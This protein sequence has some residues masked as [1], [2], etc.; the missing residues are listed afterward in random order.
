METTVV[1]EF[2]VAFLSL[3][4]LL[5][6]R[7]FSL[8][9]SP[10]L[11]PGPKPLPILG[12]LLLL[13]K[14]PSLGDCATDLEHKFGPIV[15]LW[16]W[17]QPIVFISGPDIIQEAMITE[18]S[19]FTG[20]PRL[21][22]TRYLSD[23]HR[24]LLTTHGERHR[25]LRKLLVSRVLSNKRVAE[26]RPIRERE[27]DTLIESLKNQIL[28]HDGNIK[29]GTVTNFRSMIRFTI[30]NLIVGILIG[31][32]LTPEEFANL[33]EVMLLR[34]RLSGGKP[35]DFLPW[36][37]WLPDKEGVKRQKEVRERTSQVVKPLVEERKEALKSGKTDLG[38]I[39]DTLLGLQSG[40]IQSPIEILDSDI[41][42]LFIEMLNG[43]T[44]TTALTLE[45]CIANLINHPEMQE[46]LAQEISSVAG[47]RVVGEDDIRRLPY[48]QALVTEN[49]RRHS[50]APLSARRA[51]SATKIAGYDIP[52]DCLVMQHVEAISL[53]PEIW[54]DP[55][56]FRPERFL[57]KTPD[58][59]G[60]TE[61]TMIPFGLGRRICP[62][63]HIAFIHAEFILARL[64]QAFEWKS[65]A[66]GKLVDLSPSKA[67]TAPM[68]Y[69]L[70]A[71]LQER[72]MFS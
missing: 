34:L 4:A 67:M 3:F 58:M 15:T 11:P 56:E 57:N 44:D 42:L 37:A 66:P 49:L 45:Y 71:N 30:C 8:R 69:P 53:S 33:D 39:V 40:E 41:V 19:V 16:M 20:R 28:G 51:M 60:T 5:L 24:T 35:R 12:N 31:R 21:A 25:F 48:L 38:S 70:V 47:D 18:G 43:G 10:R 52:A 17:S 54:E 22:S 59:T 68:K 36:L 61:V 1:L 6:W 26:C 9:P 63:L 65:A 32:R 2:L 27:V 14:Y 7:N 62:G 29:G 72:L 46:K 13:R 64:I 23:G 50:P 55:L